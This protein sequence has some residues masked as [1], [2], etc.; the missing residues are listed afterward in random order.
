MRGPSGSSYSSIALLPPASRR[1]GGD[2]RRGAEASL[3]RLAA[4]LH[5]KAHMSLPPWP[6]LSQASQSLRR[7]ILAQRRWHRW[8]SGLVTPASH[9]LNTRAAAAVSYGSRSVQRT[10]HLN[11]A[12]SALFWLFLHHRR[13]RPSRPPRDSLHD[14][15]T[16][17]FTATSHLFFFFFAADQPPPVRRAQTPPQPPPRLPAEAASRPS[18]STHL[19]AY[20][21]QH[22]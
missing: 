8:S 13:R 19:L 3:A 10:T 5:G 22:R 14:H 2:R 4:A 12:L 16:L 17:L 1:S 21:G 9:V 11:N 20:P 15:H 6:A 7:S 18:I